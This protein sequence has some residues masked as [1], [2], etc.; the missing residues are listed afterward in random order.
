[1]GL[2]TSVQFVKSIIYQSKNDYT[3]MLH[4]NGKT[5]GNTKQ[6]FA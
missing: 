6:Q 5:D 4:I 3:I 1:M 2:H